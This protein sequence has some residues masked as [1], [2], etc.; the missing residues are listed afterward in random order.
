MGGRG[1]AAVVGVVGG[2]QPLHCILLLGV[3]ADY[4]LVLWGCLVD[5]PG[6][7]HP[8]WGRQQALP[9]AWFVPARKGPRQQQI[10]QSMGL[11]PAASCGIMPVAWHT[12]YWL[13]GLLWCLQDRC[14]KPALPVVTG[15]KGPG[16]TGV[17]LDRTPW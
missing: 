3:C 6:G 16:V 9:G 2:G 10:R 11:L 14:A 12:A 5:L 7:R 4:V 1:A 13:A 8:I 15:H 17:L